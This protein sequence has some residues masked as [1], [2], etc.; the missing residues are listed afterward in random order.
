MGDVYYRDF[1]PEL[2]QFGYK[3][4]LNMVPSSMALV[5]TERLLYCIWSSIYKHVFFGMDYG[6][7]SLFMMHPE[8]AL[9]SDGMTALFYQKSWSVIKDDVVNMVNDF[10]SSGS[11]DDRLN[12][13]NICLIPKTVGPNRMTE[14]RSISLYNVGCKII[15]KVLCQ[16]LKRIL[17]L[18]ISETQ[19]AFVSGRL[20][21]DNILIA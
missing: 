13:L 8:K 1:L 4:I 21:S 17:P 19:S 12:M 11:F 5:C 16:R 10:L 9:D 7:D 6:M 20:I 14:L 2:E 15:S 3:D 18:L